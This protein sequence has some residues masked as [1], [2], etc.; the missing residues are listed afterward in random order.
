MLAFMR[1]SSARDASTA[2]NPTSFI[3]ALNAMSAAK[4]HS[5][6]CLQGNPGR[7]DLLGFEADQI[8]PCNMKMCLRGYALR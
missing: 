4:G 3:G 6:I 1:S 7:L 2:V 5:W 8:R